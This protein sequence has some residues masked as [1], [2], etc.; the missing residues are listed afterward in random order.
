MIAPFT[1]S[2]L[3]WG[4]G[5]LIIKVSSLLPSSGSFA[6]SYTCTCLSAINPDFFTATSEP[7]LWD[8]P[9]PPAQSC[10]HEQCT[11][12]CHIPALQQDLQQV[13]PQLLTA[14]QHYP[15]TDFHIKAA[16]IYLEVPQD[17]LSATT[18]FTEQHLHISEYVE[19]FKELY[20]KKRNTGMQKSLLLASEFMA[21]NEV[22]S[23]AV[24]YCCTTKPVR[25]KQRRQPCRTINCHKPNWHQEMLKNHMKT[26]PKMGHRGPFGSCS[27]AGRGCRQRGDVSPWPPPSHSRDGMGAGI[28][29]GFSLAFI[30]SVQSSNL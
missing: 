21:G 11:P 2:T 3:P 18:T 19:L 4:I 29:C 23:S 10:S 26:T 6:F 30:H 15:W 20:L 5:I 22:I 13:A 14:L 1:V 12:Q 28:P 24:I 7:L 25:Y 16:N 27:F 17:T 9:L 8:F